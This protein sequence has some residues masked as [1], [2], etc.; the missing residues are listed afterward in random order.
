MEHSNTTNYEKEAHLLIDKLYECM[1]DYLK[2]RGH[3]PIKK[4]ERRYGILVAN[5]YRRVTFE[6]GNKEGVWKMTYIPALDSIEIRSGKILLQK[7]LSVGVLDYWKITNLLDDLISLIE[8]WYDS[9]Q[10]KPT[11]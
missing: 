11:L 4:Q 5:D 2:Y 9:Q 3:N 8:R 10:S 1:I 7:N 6:V